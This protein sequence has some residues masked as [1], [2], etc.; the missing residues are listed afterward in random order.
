MIVTISRH[1]SGGEGLLL[2]ISAIGRI[3]GD[4][5]HARPNG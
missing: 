2:N 4:A 1:L 5:S 3:M